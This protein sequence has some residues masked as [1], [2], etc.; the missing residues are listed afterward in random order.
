MRIT[1]GVL[2]GL[3]LVVEALASG[4]GCADDSGG[5]ADAGEDVGVD[6]DADAGADADSDAD[7]TEDV[8]ADGD[9]TADGGEECAPGCDG[10]PCDVGEWAT[11]CPGTFQM[12]SPATEPGRDDVETQHSVTLTHRFEI[13]STEVTQAE[14]QERMGYNPSVFSWGP[15]EMVNWHEAAAYCNALSSAGGLA[16]CYACSGSA[17]AVTCDLSTLYA[18]P[19]A[20][21][22]YRLPTEAEWEY[23]ARAGTTGGTYNGT[24]DAAHLGCEYPNLVLEPIAWFCESYGSPHP[25]GTREPNAWGLYD[26]LGNMWEWCGDWWDHVDYPAGAA[27]D[28]WGLSAGSSRVFRGGSW[29][30]VAGDARAATRVWTDPA[31]ATVDKGFRPVRTLP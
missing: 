3:G 4:V 17:A 22:G 15:V 16:N 24:C 18:N 14:F 23:A 9:D 2:L 20:C 6:G 26:M 10:G 29:F 28:P 11:I 12:G 31:T 5:D 27:T 25:G 19:Y 13:L 30:N 7:T 1:A 21:P 8:A